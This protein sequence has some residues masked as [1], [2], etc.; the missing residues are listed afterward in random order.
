MDNTNSNNRAHLIPDN[1]HGGDHRVDPLA[2]RSVRCVSTTPSTSEQDN[3]II[4]QDFCQAANQ[5][6]STGA[7]L[8]GNQA[9]QVNRELLELAPPIRQNNNKKSCPDAHEDESSPRRPTK[10]RRTIPPATQALLKQA[11]QAKR[12]AILMRQLERIQA[13]LFLELADSLQ[14]PSES[15]SSSSPTVAPDD[16]SGLVPRG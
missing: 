14:V 2:P 16:S 6:R 8:I 3:R 5:V 13:H 9:L 1:D 15:E 4:F 11:H 12:M 10:K 7:A